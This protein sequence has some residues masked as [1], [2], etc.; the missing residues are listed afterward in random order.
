[1]TFHNNLSICLCFRL[2]QP[3]WAV[4][5]WWKKSQDKGKFS[6]RGWWKYQQRHLYS[7]L[8]LVTTSIVVWYSLIKSTE[9]GCSIHHPTDNKIGDNFAILSQGTW[10]YVWMKIHLSWVAELAVQCLEANAHIKL[11]SPCIEHHLKH[12]FIQEK[13]GALQGLHFFSWF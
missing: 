8:C 12:H 2:L 10:Y 4:S 13:N 6:K 5:M 11:T 9:S 7:W 3:C 1:M